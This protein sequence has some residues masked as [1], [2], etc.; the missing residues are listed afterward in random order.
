MIERV[1][2]ADL[3]G[4][5][6]D[7]HLQL[8]TITGLGYNGLTINLANAERSKKPLGQDSRVRQALEL[9]I[10]RDALDQVVFDGEFQP[11]NQWVAPTNPYCMKEL[12]DPG[13]RCGQG[14][15]FARGGWCALTQSFRLIVPQQPRDLASCSGHPGNVPGERFQHAAPGDSVFASAL[16]LA[17][18]GDFEAF[19]LGWSGRSRPGRRCSS[20]CCSCEAPPR[21]ST[22]HVVCDQNVDRELNAAREAAAR[23]ERLAH[24]RHQSRRILA[25]RPS[26]IFITPSCCMPRQ[27]NLAWLRPYPDGLIRPQGLRLD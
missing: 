24:Y 5:R 16:Q 10:D 26:C 3:N 4:V 27:Q 1:A 21:H 13:A 12:A 11:G 15:S 18:K 8:A 23:A 2:A 6:K 7:P 22:F 20:F 19:M 25:N 14:E 9:S 17:A